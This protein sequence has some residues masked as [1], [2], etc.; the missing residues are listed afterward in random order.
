MAVTHYQRLSSAMLDYIGLAADDKP[1]P[2]QPG[3]K[4]YESDTG[5]TWIWTGAAWV[6]LKSPALYAP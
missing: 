5:K 4:Y 6:E 3:S 1:T 2:D